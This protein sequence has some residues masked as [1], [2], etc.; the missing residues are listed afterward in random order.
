MRKILT[1]ICMAASLLSYAQN[2]FDFNAR[3]KIEELKDNKTQALKNDKN[4][5]TEISAEENLTFI[6]RFKDNVEP[7]SFLQDFEIKD[8]RGSMCIIRGNLAGIERLAAHPEVLSVTLDTQY[9][10]Q[11]ITARSLMEVDQIH[12]GI[13]GMEGM[14]FTG[15]GVITGIYDSGLD[16]NHVNFKDSEGRHRTKVL[17]HYPNSNT[18]EFYE[19]EEEISR[20]TTDSDESYHGTH[21]LGIMAGGYSG[22]AQYA[23]YGTPGVVE[24][25]DATTSPYYGVAPEADII[26][27]CGLGYQSSIL[28]TMGNIV[29]YS[30][31]HNQPCIFNLSFGTNLGPHDG[32]DAFN[33]Y[34]AEFGKEAIICVAAGNEGNL[35]ISFS[36]IG[37]PIQTLI[38]SNTGGDQILGDIEL[39]GSDDSAF[40]VYFIGYDLNKGEVY[41][42]MLN[43]NLA[44]RVIDLSQTSGFKN[45]FNGSARISSNIN[46]DNNRYCVS[47]SMTTQGKS[48]SIYPGI[49]IE[50]KDKDQKVNGFSNT[51]TQFVSKDIPGFS[52]GTPENSISNTACGDNIIVVGS[53]ASN[54]YMKTVE[55]KS[56]YFVANEGDI[57]DY[58]SYGY[59]KDNRCLPDVCAPGQVVIS[60]YNRYYIKKEWF[61][62]EL[63]TCIYTPLSNKELPSYWAYAS[64][65]SMA[66]P[67]VAGTI[68]LWLEADP[69]LDVDDIKELIRTTST[70]DSF[71]SQNPKRWGAGKINALA[72]IKKILNVGSGIGTVPVDFESEVT[73]SPDGRIFN[74]S[75]YEDHHVM[76]TLHSLSGMCVKRVSGIG[77][78]TLSADNVS[79]GIYFLRV[80]TPNGSE[81][82][83]VLIR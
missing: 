48:S 10:P 65:T 11:M 62:P 25:K 3:Q 15:K 24:Q 41:R 34:L 6:V 79:P 46:P 18:E 52:D 20:F 21:V 22:P 50:P 13:A 70:Q 38:E 76:A 53:Y 27:G 56:Y 12:T 80:N 72:G 2:K 43:N 16:I 77:S 30:K 67:M 47:L 28:K 71:T 44:G 39:W 64:G 73:V 40:T 54:K 36:T 63:S 9:E 35:K 66:T 4:S 37:N 74:I 1:I 68:A 57:S 49:I 31:S 61:K 75:T 60:S 81:A 26:A 32:T 59:T 14:K 8:I 51:T 78:I 55:D 23:V 42:Y 83:K 7:N 5:I 17:Y 69:T 58:S 82:R 29:D 19:G 33:R 45:V